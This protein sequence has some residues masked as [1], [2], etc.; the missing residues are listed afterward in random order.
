[1]RTLIG[2]LLEQNNG[3]AP[4][5]DKREGFFQGKGRGGR[6]VAWRALGLIHCFMLSWAG[7]LMWAK[8]SN[9]SQHLTKVEHFFSACR[10]EIRPGKS[11]M[12]C[13][14]QSDCLGK[15]DPN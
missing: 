5:E 7:R 3:F 6:Q 15:G 14:E 1:M 10:R 13:Q 12:K 9:A 8:T 2:E 4:W 11:E